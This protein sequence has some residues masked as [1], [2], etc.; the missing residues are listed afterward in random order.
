MRGS[1]RLLNETSELVCDVR[2]ALAAAFLGSL[3]DNDCASSQRA[4]EDAQDAAASR[5]VALCDCSDART[6]LVAC[7]PELKSHW[8][9]SE[10]RWSEFRQLW[11]LL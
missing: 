9:F 10:D 3:P 4:A 1:G 2:I 5:S 8:H 6:L 7:N 11:S